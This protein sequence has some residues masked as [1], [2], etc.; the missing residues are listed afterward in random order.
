[1]RLNIEQDQGWMDDDTGLNAIRL[2]CSNDDVLQSPNEVSSGDWRKSVSSS[3]S[4]VAVQ[5]K[6]ESKQGAADDTGANGIRF[7]DCTGEEF[8]PGEG[9]FGSWSDYV[10]CQTGTVITG[11]RTRVESLQTFAD[12]TALNQIQYLFQQF[13]LA[14]DI[15]LHLY[16]D[17]GLEI[18][19]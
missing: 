10:S 1:M 9:P 17:L 13:L 15:H 16:F 19:F 12:N 3:N 14:K 7:K 5:L 18:Q 8:R 6:S 2:I 11:F 4:I